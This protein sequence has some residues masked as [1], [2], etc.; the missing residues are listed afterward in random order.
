MSCKFL[1]F[2]QRH[3]ISQVLDAV[4]AY[5]IAVFSTYSYP[6]FGAP[7]LRFSIGGSSAHSASFQ[8][9]ERRLQRDLI[10][11]RRVVKV[12][13]KLSN[14]SKQKFRKSQSLGAFL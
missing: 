14:F 9:F 5:P 3:A 4:D 11:S 8:L 2:G 7:F 10:T 6:A 1:L 12:T 13:G